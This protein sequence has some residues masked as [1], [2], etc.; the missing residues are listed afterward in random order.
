[1]VGGRR[2]WRRRD[3]R[4][5]GR[6]G[7]CC[8]DCRLPR[9]T[10]G[11]RVTPACVLTIAGSDS[12]GGAGIQA[13]LATF[14]AFGVH[15]TSALTA[16]TAQNTIGVQGVHVVPP[17]FVDL[18]LRSVLDDFTVGAAKTGMLATAEIISIVA[19]RA[20]GNELPNLVVDPVMIATSGHRLLDADAERAYLDALFPHAVVVTPNARGPRYVVIKGGHLDGN[21]SVDVVFDGTDIEFLHAPRVASVNTHGTGCTFSAAITARLALGDPPDRAISVAKRY[22]TS[23]I[24]A[25]SGWRLGHGHGPVDH[26]R[27][28]PSPG[29]NR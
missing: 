2:A 27:H 5:H 28:A 26:F 17:A 15:G 6:R 21:E 3:G 1:M 18:Q 24:E 7:P 10:R 13:D 8:D 25:A 23:A 20:A 19:R 9:L 11:G 16:L 22:I 4:H 14:A 12:G 29:E